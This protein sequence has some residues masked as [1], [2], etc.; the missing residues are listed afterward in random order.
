[1][2][3]GAE[4]DWISA[5]GS[6]C[7]CVERRGEAING[8]WTPRFS[9]SPAICTSFSTISGVSGGGGG[10]GDVVARGCAFVDSIGI[11]IVT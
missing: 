5:A 10:D 7:I 11:D 9:A 4:T 8:S 2:T 1:M 6:P 3:A